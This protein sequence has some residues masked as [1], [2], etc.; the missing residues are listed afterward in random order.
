MEEWNENVPADDD[1]LKDG[2]DAI[3][4]LKRA[5]RERL[6][7]EHYYHPAIDE[8]IPIQ[9]IGRHRIPHLKNLTT[10]SFANEYDNGDSGTIKTITWTNGQKQRI[11]LTDDCDLEFDPPFGACNL[12][13]RVIQDF[14]GG[15]TIIWP[16]M[17]KWPNGMP[18]P[19]SK[20]ADA[21]D[22]ISIYYDGIDYYGEFALNFLPEDFNDN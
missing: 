3:R 11:T 1:F 4:Q 5:A 14:V 21:I 18:P 12:I 6:N 10:A 2:D 20:K 19:L 16:E 22:I 15:R 8:T 13:L 17:M 7:I 9:D